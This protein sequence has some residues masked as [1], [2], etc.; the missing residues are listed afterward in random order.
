VSPFSTVYILPVSETQDNTAITTTCGG[1]SSSFSY[2]SFRPAGSPPSEIS[3]SASLVASAAAPTISDG[4]GPVAVG[5]ALAIHGLR[6][7]ARDQAHDRHGAQLARGG[8]APAVA[9]QRLEPIVQGVPEPPRQEHGG[10]A[11]ALPEVD[12]EAG[13]VDA[14]PAAR[15][16]HAAP[17][18]SSGSRISRRYLPSH[19]ISLHGH[20]SGHAAPKVER[21]VA[22]ALVQ[23]KAS[24]GSPARNASELPS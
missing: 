16:A 18:R 3:D 12:G 6:P 7:F 15:G 11:L 21:P 22:E 14:S 23:A 20:R 17:L 24:M 10:Q 5:D 19:R 8:V 9:A 13:V 2:R 4:P 1:V